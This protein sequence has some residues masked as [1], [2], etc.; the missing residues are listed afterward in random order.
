MQCEK[1]VRH[2]NTR[3]PPPHHLDESIASLP[4]KKKRS[5]YKQKEELQEKQHELSNDTQRSSNFECKHVFSAM[6]T[7]KKSSSLERIR[8]LTSIARS[9]ATH[10]MQASQLKKER[11]A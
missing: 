3:S 9:A 5:K 7:N 6:R 8:C 10:C 4:E 11:R 1:E 2:T